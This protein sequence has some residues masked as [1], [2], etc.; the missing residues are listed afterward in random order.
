MLDSRPLRAA[1]Y[2]HS[3]PPAKRQAIAGRLVEILPAM[4][5]LD[6][7]GASQ[8]IE[9]LERPSGGGLQV[10]PGLLRQPHR[11]GFVQLA[12][13]ACD[14]CRFD[15]EQA[16]KEIWDGPFADAGR[17]DAGGEDAAGD[18]LENALDV[19]FDEAVDTGGAVGASVRR[20]IEPPRDLVGDALAAPLID[21]VIDLLA[22]ATPDRPA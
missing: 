4:R 13:L 1:K 7:P 12:V 14:W 11:G 18:L 20:L 6:E 21:S 17:K 15:R 8:A 2:L 10:P 19:A 22:R 9:D 16:L 5:G 3:L